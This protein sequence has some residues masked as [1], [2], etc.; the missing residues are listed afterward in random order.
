MLSLPGNEFFDGICLWLTPN[1]SYLQFRRDIDFPNDG[2]KIAKVK[3]LVDNGYADRVVLSQDI[4][5][6][7][8]LVMIH[9]RLITPVNVKYD[10]SFHE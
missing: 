5:T 1:I 9:R 8:R 2:E 7:N 6:K 3:F 4:H 10:E